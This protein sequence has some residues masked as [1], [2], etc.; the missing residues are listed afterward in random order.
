MIKQTQEVHS[1]KKT[2]KAKD[3]YV[4]L[5]CLVGLSLIIEIGCQSATLLPLKSL[6]YQEYYS[7]DLV[8]VY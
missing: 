8:L 6:V 4:C 2:N 7:G 3:I 5:I 1:R